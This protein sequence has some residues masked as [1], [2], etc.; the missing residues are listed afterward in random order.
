MAQGPGLTVRVAEGH[1]P[2]LH[3]IVAVGAF[4]CGERA[5]VH[6]VWNIQKL[7][8][9]NHIA[10]I[11]PYIARN[12]QQPGNPHKQSGYSSYILGDATHSEGSCP[13][14]QTHI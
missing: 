5:L 3:L 8:T 4:F 9:Q 2:E 6:L 13:S 10:G 7:E 12:F 14:F 1:V 11:D